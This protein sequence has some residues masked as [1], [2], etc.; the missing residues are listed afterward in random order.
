MRNWLTGALQGKVMAGEYGYT[1]Q[2]FLATNRLCTVVLYSKSGI[3]VYWSAIRITR[4]ETRII[5]VYGNV[6]YPRKRIILSMLS[7]RIWSFSIKRE[8]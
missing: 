5:I 6:S 7:T 8:N 2:V 4:M 1:F 3:T